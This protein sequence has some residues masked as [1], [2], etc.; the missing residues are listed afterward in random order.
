MI[1]PFLKP[2]AG[3][4]FYVYRFFGGFSKGF[5]GKNRPAEAPGKCMTPLRVSNLP[6]RTP[7]RNKGGSYTKGGG[8]TLLT[9]LIPT[10]APMVH[11]QLKADSFSYNI[12]IT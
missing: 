3:E 7:A 11:D 9:P 5:R 1:L 4:I 10:R 8:H 12:I 6:D 2:A